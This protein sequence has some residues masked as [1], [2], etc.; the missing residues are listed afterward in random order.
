MKC[1]QC[2]L[3]LRNRSLRSL[4]QGP[5]SQDEYVFDDLDFNDPALNDLIGYDNPAT[6][7]VIEEK[8]RQDTAFADLV[9]FRLSP[10]IFKL[11]SAI[12]TPDLTKPRSAPIVT[13][14]SQ[15]GTDYV[16]RGVQTWV[17]CA[18]VLVDNHLRVR[19]F[20]LILVRT[21]RYSYRHGTITSFLAMRPIN[22]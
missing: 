17:N 10:S 12:Y 6:T 20:S 22:E 7:S 15:S 8:R 4:S 13:Q 1:V 11:L 19:Y 18:A 3:N 2:F 21:H 5:V 14:S 16:F 9:K